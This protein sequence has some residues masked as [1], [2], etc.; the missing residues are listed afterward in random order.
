MN[1]KANSNNRRTRIIMLIVFVAVLAVPIISW[2]FVKGHVNTENQENRSFAE[3]PEISLE[4]AW[5]ITSGID[6]WFNDRIP[7]KN[8]AMN[9]TSAIK[10]ETEARKPLA[11]YLSDTR[12]IVG[13]DDWLFYNGTEGESTIP[14]YM[15]GNLYTEKELKTLAEGYQ[16]VADQYREMGSEV[17]LFVPPNKEQVY[18]EFMPEVLGEITANSRMD[19]FISYMKEHVDFPVIYAKEDLLKAKDAGYQVYFKYDSHWNYLGAFLG[20]QLIAKEILGT[21]DTLEEHTIGQYLDFEGEPVTADRD[22]ARMLGLGPKY[23]EDFNPAVMDYKMEV[24]EHLGFWVNEE[25]VTYMI[26]ESIAE[27]D[28]DVLMFHDSFAYYMDEIM[29]RDYKRLALLEDAE[30]VKQYVESQHPDYVI[31]EIAER[32]QDVLDSV[33]QEL[34]LH[35]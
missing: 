3:F 33:W 35:E 30:Y 5:N 26:W 15:G 11:S 32:K 12:V 22:L 8:Q 20:T 27:N 34:L 14:D 19:Q 24:Y 29:G 25:Q 9:L 6:D 1:N 28:L 4:N 18:S 2:P 16:K 31:L 13:R 10:L 21:K 7:Y 17:I 23:T